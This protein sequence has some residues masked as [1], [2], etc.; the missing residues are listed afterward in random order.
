M[1]RSFFFLRRVWRM[2]AADRGLQGVA[3]L[4]TALNVL[5]AA[6]V[7]GGAAL[8]LGEVDER[9]FAGVVGA[10]LAFPVTAIGTFCNVALLRM[11]E[12]RFDGRTCTAREGFAAARERLPAILAWSLLL[13][14]VGALLRQVAERVPFGGA[15]LSWLLGTAWSLATMFAVPVLALEDAGARRATLRSAQLFRARWGEGM[16]GTFAV[17]AITTMVSIPAVTLVVLGLAAGTTVGT[18]VAGLGVALCVAAV[19]VSRAMD[20]LFALALYRHETR[21]AASFGLVGGQLDRFVAVK[22]R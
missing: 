18:A 6:L 4:A 15:L 5:A 7:F 20:E 3:L 11:A 9:V 8:V 17:G 1:A 12:A 21:G 19:T 22:R 2:F 10:V 16:T 13:V 14:G